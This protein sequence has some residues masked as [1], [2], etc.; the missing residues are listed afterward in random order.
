MR[1]VWW[2]L[3]IIVIAVILSTVKTLGP[4]L[5]GAYIDPAPSSGFQGFETASNAA[6]AAQSIASSMYNATSNTF[7]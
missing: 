6:T 3:I 1:I 4:N 5:R 7:G 2:L